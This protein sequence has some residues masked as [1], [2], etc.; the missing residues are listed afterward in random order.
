LGLPRYDEC[1]Y[2]WKFEGGRLDYLESSGTILGRAAARA[3]VVL[4]SG[5][6]ADRWTWWSKSRNK[7]SH[8]MG[9]VEVEAL[10]GASLTIQRGEMVAIMGPSGS[11]KSTMMN[12]L[13]MP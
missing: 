12:I 10:R 13:G 7:K 11:G 4:S 8:K 2:G 5:L 3:A 1:C 6:E 9:E